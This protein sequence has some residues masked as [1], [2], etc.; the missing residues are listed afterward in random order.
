MAHQ[1]DISKKGKARMAYNWHRGT[2]WHKLGVPVDGDSSVTEI[3]QACGANY[4]VQIRPLI[5]P[6]PDNPDRMMETD[7]QYTF[8]VD[9]DTGHNEWLGTTGLDYRVIQDRTT[10]EVALKVAGLNPDHPVV[11]V[12]GLLDRGR[13]FFATIPLPDYILDPDGIADRI[14]NQMVVSNGHN[15]SHAF[16]MANGGVRAVCANTVQY[17]QHRAARQVSI[18]HTKAAADIPLS[19]IRRQMGFLQSGAAEFEAMM[20]EMHGKP[21]GW[22]TVETMAEVFWPAKDDPTQRQQ[23]IRDNRLATLEELWAV[24]AGRVGQTGW[25]AFNTLQGFF[26]HEQGNSGDR[27]SVARL[28]RSVDGG[29]YAKSVARAAELVLAR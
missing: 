25:A 24:E 20:W 8:R 13:R 11:D 27:E 2:P 6:D 19:Y 29:G 14:I 5:I 12:A 7:Q 22:T 10:L 28:N 4:E 3:L 21:A 9:P 18:R 1:L 17:A 15:G 16:N 26:Q 23:T